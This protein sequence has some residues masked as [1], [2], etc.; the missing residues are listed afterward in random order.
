MFLSC[1]NLLCEAPWSKGYLGNKVLE[2]GIIFVFLNLTVSKDMLIAL[3]V[4]GIHPELMKGL[5]GLYRTSL[6]RKPGSHP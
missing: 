5:G 1:R 6:N 3:V 4:N 2:Y